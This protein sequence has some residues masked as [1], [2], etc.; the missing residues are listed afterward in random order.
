M[1]RNDV[2]IQTDPNG[3]KYA[4]LA[5]DKITETDRGEALSVMKACRRDSCMQL[6]E[7]QLRVRFA[8]LERIFLY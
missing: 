2:Q 4:T 7:S 5:R 3:I 1:G 8:A 6:L